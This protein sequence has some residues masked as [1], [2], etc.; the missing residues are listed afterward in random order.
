M[1][2]RVYIVPA[3]EG[4][5]QS[6]TVNGPNIAAASSREYDP[7]TDSSDLVNTIISEQNALTSTLPPTD[8]LFAVASHETDSKIAEVKAVN[9]KSRRSR[10]K[11]QFAD[12]KDEKQNIWKAGGSKKGKDGSKVADNEG[13][14]DGKSLRAFRCALVE[15]VKE[16]L[17]PT[18]KEK[19][20]KEEA[21]KTIVKK[22]EYKVIS[23]FQS[24]INIPRM[25]ENI[26]KY[27]DA[28]ELKIS[29]LVQVCADPLRL[30][31]FHPFFLFSFA[32]IKFD[33]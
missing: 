16:L 3:E 28:S 24:S 2:C 21:Y 10:E 32:R 22:V 14:T 17:S 27:L 20:I 29:N 9:V 6:G 18:W 13:D 31:K 15:V 30:N 11:E 8:N 33:V 25:Q 5:R 7:V 23:S 1:D 26:N 4:S 19:K 12:C